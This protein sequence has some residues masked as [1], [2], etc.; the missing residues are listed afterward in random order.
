MCNIW[1]CTSPKIGKEIHMQLTADIG[2]ALLWLC[3]IQMPLALAPFSVY[4]IFHVATYTRSNLLPTVQPQEQGKQASGLSET[5][6]RFV[7][8]YYDSSMTLVALLEIFL[9]FRILGSAIIFQKGSWILLIAY[10]VFF[11]AR[12]SQ[13]H[14]MQNA[15]TQLAARIDSQVANQSTPPAVRNVW[16]QVKGYVRQAAD[17]TDLNKLSRQQQGGPPKKAQ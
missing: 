10:T 6:G 14:F 2:M 8:D 13:S 9:W 15:F 1:V 11:R 12:H 17:A 4:S 7:R 16:E 3:A 5:I